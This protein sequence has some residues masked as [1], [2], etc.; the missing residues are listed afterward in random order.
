LIEVAD[1]V[2]REAWLDPGLHQIAHPDLDHLRV[3][4]RVVRSDRLDAQLKE[5][6]VAAFL[7]TLLPE[8]PAR[9]RDL[10]RER[11]SLEPMLEHGADH[12]RGPLG[13]QGQGAAAPVLERVHLLGD[14]LGCCTDAA[15]ED[16]RVLESR[17]LDRGVATGGED[18][19]GEPHESVPIPRLRREHVVRAPGRA[20][21]FGSI[22]HGGS[23]RA[24]NRRP[25]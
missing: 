19:E 7:R 11:P 22:G 15:L 17:S 14:H 1:G 16:L 8:H 6:T 20:E 23:L 4:T 25:L 21:T 12:R 13:S 18:V 9:V 24:G 2:E 5:L 3:G 10:D